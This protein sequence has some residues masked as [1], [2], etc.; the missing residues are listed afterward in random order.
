MKSYN[1]GLV[2]RANRIGVVTEAAFL[3]ACQ[4]VLDA[5]TLVDLGSV[6]SAHL[7][8]VRLFGD[9]AVRLFTEVHTFRK[10][11]LECAMQ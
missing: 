10:G 1:A 5:R 8:T 3:D 6:F 9:D 4:E 2:Q 11:E 7:G